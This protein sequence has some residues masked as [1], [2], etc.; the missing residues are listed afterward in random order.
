[1]EGLHETR[2]LGAVTV[3]AMGMLAV[4]ALAP[5]SHRAWV[6]ASIPYAGMIGIAPVGLRSDLE[7]GFAATVF[8]YLCVWATDI[9]AYVVGR[10]LGGPKLLPKVSPKKTWSGSI[11]G[12]AA[13]AIVAAAFAHVWDLAHVPALVVVAI[14]LSMVA[15]AGDL[16]ESSLKRR[17]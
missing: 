17:F 2:L 9:L 3:L 16:F 12:I 11:G 8:V 5:R 7:Y 1:K 14:V 13:A 15:Q 6:A 4:A 10:A